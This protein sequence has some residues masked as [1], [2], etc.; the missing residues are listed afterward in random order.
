MS[1]YVL[2]TDHISLLLQGHPAVSERV[3]EVTPDLAITIVSVQEIFNGWVVRMND[4]A[5]AGNLVGLYTKLWTTLEFFRG[6]RVLNFDAAA[7]D[8]CERLLRENPLLGKKRLQKDVRIAAIALSLAGVMLT[9]N[10][11]DFELVPGLML[12]DWT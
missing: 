3:A 8:C 12:E 2:D 5:Q 7:N 11:K 6:V 10:R 9:R 4:P 1:L